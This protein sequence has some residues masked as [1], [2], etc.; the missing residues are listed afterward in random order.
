MAFHMKL[1][2]IDRHTHYA[3]DWTAI[4]VTTREGYLALHVARRHRQITLNCYP[5]V[6]EVEEAARTLLMNAYK[7]KGSEAF[8]A[9]SHELWDL[10]IR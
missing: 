8:S 5:L 9:T 1:K 7:R 6:I 10:R 3:Q 4:Q 2:E